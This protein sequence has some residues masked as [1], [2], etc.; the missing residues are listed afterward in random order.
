[1]AL[2]ASIAG[3]LAVTQIDAAL[4]KRFIPWLLLAAG[5]YALATPEL[6]NA[7]GRRRMKPWGFALLF[8]ALLGFYDGFFGPGTGS[9]WTLAFVLLCGLELRQAT[10]HTKAVNLAS[11][12]GSLLVFLPAGT[13]HY[14]YGAVMIV[15]QLLGAYLG[16]HMV[17]TRGTRFIRVLF[18]TVVFALA[19]KLLWKQAAS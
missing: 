18:L 15:G 4:L 16:S 6:G 13:I 7:P 3:A 17:I 10:A 2:P 5:I 9:F 1:M 8:G 12:V 14:G 19:V 11:N